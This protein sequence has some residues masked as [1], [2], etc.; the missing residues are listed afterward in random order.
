MLRPASRRLA[1]PWSHSDLSRLKLLE[2]NTKGMLEKAAKSMRLPFLEEDL[3]A[4][5]LAAGAKS[6]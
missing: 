6:P 4:L 5:Q 3:T 2:R 1:R